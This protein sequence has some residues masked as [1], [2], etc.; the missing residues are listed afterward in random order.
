MSKSLPPSESGACPRM[1]G[2]KIPFEGLIRFGSGFEIV[3]IVCLL[4]VGQIISDSEI[5]FS[6]LDKLDSPLL[7]NEIN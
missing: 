5:R 6:G 7:T 4:Q 1:I 2:F 3:I